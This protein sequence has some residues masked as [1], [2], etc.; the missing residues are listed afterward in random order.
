MT[1]V[2]SQFLNIRLLEFQRASVMGE[3]GPAMCHVRFLCAGF[4]VV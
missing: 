2:N 1:G 4:G 3:P